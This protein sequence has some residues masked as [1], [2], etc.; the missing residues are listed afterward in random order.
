M[1]KPDRAA[2]RPPGSRIQDPRSLALLVD[3]WFVTYYVTNRFGELPGAGRIVVRGARGFCGLKQ[4][5]AGA[6]DG[7]GVSVGVEPFCR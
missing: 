7:G 6:I 5:C 3:P 4:T 1:S 2:P